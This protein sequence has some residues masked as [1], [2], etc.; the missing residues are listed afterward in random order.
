MPRGARQVT[1]PDFYE[2]PQSYDWLTE[3]YDLAN[4]RSGLIYD[5]A[6]QAIRREPEP[7]DGIDA[8]RHRQARAPSRASSRG[9]VHN[10]GGS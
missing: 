2:S 8:E 3:N 4:N 9:E 1:R 7:A 5:A 10:C 6:K